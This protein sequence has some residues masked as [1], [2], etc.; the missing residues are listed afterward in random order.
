MTEATATQ[1]PEKIQPPKVETANDEAIANYLRYTCKIAEI[2][3]LAE[4]DAAIV[5]ACEELGIV[6]L[7]EELQ[8]A[9]DEF[10]V[11]HKLLGASE[12]LAWLAKQR[13]SPEDW[14]QGI[15]IKLLTQKLKEHLFLD[16]ID[17]HYLSYREEYQRVAFSQI[18]VAE[19]PAALQIVRNLREE[20]A[21]FAAMAIEHSQSHPSSQ[22]G[23]FVGIRFVSS[24]LPEIK[25]AIAGVREGE[26][27]DPVKTHLGY[28][29]LRVEKWFAPSLNESVRTEILEILF[30]TWLNSR[31]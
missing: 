21:A 28:H 25:E 14:T 11:K 3:A 22:H 17:A 30:Q 15:K 19:L 8:A 5:K 31:S 2:A 24:L 13:I 7:D 23:G 6:V 9:G 18:M 29:I 26:I 20:K 4:R 12:T 1:L 16:T 10:R 27:V